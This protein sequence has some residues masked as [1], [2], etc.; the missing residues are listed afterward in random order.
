MSTA[1]DKI[2]QLEQE[3]NS[4]YALLVAVLM[5]TGPVEFSLNDKPKPGT[6][7]RLTEHPGN[8]FTVGLESE[9]VDGQS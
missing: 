5:K 3:L 6:V 7:V 1:E 2:A 4:N 8:F 9:V